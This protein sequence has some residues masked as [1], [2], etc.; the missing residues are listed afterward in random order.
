VLRLRKK[1]CLNPKPLSALKCGLVRYFRLGADTSTELVIGPLLIL[2]ELHEEDDEASD[3]DDSWETATS[4]EE[5][6]INDSEPL[7][8]VRNKGAG[9]YG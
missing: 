4:D 2:M 6:K 3:T 1:G 7:S 8:L 5:P 9:N